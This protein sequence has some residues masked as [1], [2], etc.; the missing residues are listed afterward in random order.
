MPPFQVPASMTV[1]AQLY[2]LTLVFPS[3]HPDVHKAASCCLLLP[4]LPPCACLSVFSKWLL[5]L[6]FLH[7]LLASQPLVPWAFLESP[8]IL[9]EDLCSSY[10]WSGHGHTLLAEDRDIVMHRV[11]TGTRLLPPACLT[12]LNLHNT[13]GR[14]LS[15]ILLT[16]DAWPSRQS[17]CP[18]ASS[19]LCPSLTISF[20]CPLFAGYTVSSSFSL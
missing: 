15:P 14:N 7:S 6:A 2:V 18:R 12:T 1:P 16:M 5:L 3:L 9:Q 13:L 20:L 4:C 10:A 11:N 19:H 17:P 8:S